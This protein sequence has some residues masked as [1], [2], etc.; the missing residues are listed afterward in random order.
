MIVSYFPLREVIQSHEATGIITKWVVKLM[1]E[2]I[3]YTSRKAIKSQV[4]ANFVAE[5]TKTQ[6]PPASME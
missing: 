5:W 3:T 4:L 2:G 1:G 6:T